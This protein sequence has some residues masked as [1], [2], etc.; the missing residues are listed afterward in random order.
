[1]TRIVLPQ[2]DRSWLVTPLKELASINY[3]SALTASSRASEGE[4][5]VYGSGGVVGS[6][7]EALKHVRSIVIG[8]K[9]SVG[10][11]FLTDGPFWCIDT[12]FFLD[13]FSEIIS[14]DFLAILLKSIDL[15][16][17]AISVAVPGLNRRDLEE[18]PVPLPTLA[19]QQRIVDVLR[20]AETVSHSQVQR[21]Q[22]LDSMLKAELDRLVL[23][24]DETDWVQLGELVETR[25]GTSVSADES[26]DSGLP[27]LR[28]PNVVGGEVDMTDMKFVTL[29][30]AEIKRLQLTPQDVLIVRS[31]GNPDYVGR[32][33]PITED[34]AQWTLVYASYLIRL[35]A[36]VAR[37]LPEYLSA[38]L[39]SPY[40]RAAMRNAIRTTAGQSNLSGENLS[41]VRIPL[42]TLPEQQ[43][44]RT[45]WLEVRRLRQLIRESEAKTYELRNVLSI[46]ALSGTLTAEWRD[47]HHEEITQAAQ[48]RDALLRE[49]G[50]KP[51]RSEPV[52]MVLVESE[53]EPTTRTWLHA[54]LSDFQRAVLQVF[55]NHAPQPLLAEVEEEFD[56][57]RESE[58]LAE[59]LADFPPTSPN[60]L[61]RALS[62]LAALGLIAKVTVPRTNPGTGAQEYLTAF[63]PLRHG[64]QSRTADVA[65]LAREV[66]RRRNPSDKGPAA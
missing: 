55:L 30:D 9:G 4:I 12:A 52:A 34:L 29:P 11:V 53:A 43:R 39:N 51:T 62:Q 6:H 48:H 26:A 42:P 28:I 8:R 10:S 54:E 18:I 22:S 23:A 46:Q 56:R 2:L 44:F 61:R 32:S 41:K 35:R 19:E 36:D 40:G 5:P 45:F 14:L 63:R 3:G 20:Q 66:E 7:N 60:Q 21:H 24:I 65:L 17:L 47:Q 15:S 25:Y 49:R 38:F 57:F 33:A 58:A 64:D 59:K 1:M 13:D 50:A 31:N 37:L 27:V 16:R